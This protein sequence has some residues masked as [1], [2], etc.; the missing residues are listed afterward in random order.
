MN[1][2]NTEIHAA[3]VAMENALAT[4]THRGYGNIETFR[5]YSLEGSWGDDSRSYRVTVALD[6]DDEVLIY[7]AS[8][9]P[10][11]IENLI[12]REHWTPI[13]KYVDLWGKLLPNV[14]RMPSGPWSCW[15]C[16]V[17]F[18]P[19]MLATA[20]SCARVVEH[21][22]L[23]ASSVFYG[24]DNVLAGYNP[25]VAFVRARDRALSVPNPILELG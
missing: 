20:E 18:P 23:F 3:N 15:A 9:F 1:N 24:F 4:M 11:P 17:R 12:R 19:T 10:C 2:L 6:H 22:E 7:V 16:E 14:V 13:E 8:A 21:V 5:I 25:A